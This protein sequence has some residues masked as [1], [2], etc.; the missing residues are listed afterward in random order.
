MG[1]YIE[2]ICA[3]KW[4]YHDTGKKVTVKDQKKQRLKIKDSAA[5]HKVG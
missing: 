4:F 3:S 1:A 2:Y 5:W